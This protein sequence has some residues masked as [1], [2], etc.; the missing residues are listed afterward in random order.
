MPGTNCGVAK[1]EDQPVV[2]GGNMGTSKDTGSSGW[3]HNT[4]GA[5][6]LLPVE[7]MCARMRAAFGEGWEF[8][9]RVPSEDQ[10]SSEAFARIGAQVTAK[11]TGA[12]AYA[13]SKEVRFQHLYTLPTTIH[14][15]G[16]V[17]AST[18]AKQYNPTPYV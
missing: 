2:L 18:S 9:A 1:S 4:P 3:S 5:V 17:T 16:V 8:V 11:Y 6:M 15:V 12:A 10:K 13:R 14:S 7:N